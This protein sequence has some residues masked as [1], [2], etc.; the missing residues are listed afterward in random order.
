MLE[1]SARSGFP[2]PGYFSQFSGSVT[3][4]PPLAMEGYRKTM[5]FVSDHLNQMQDGRMMIQN[6]GVIFLS[7]DVDDFFSFCDRCQRLV[8][9]FQRIE[10]LRG[11]VELAEAAVDQDQTGHGLFLFAKTFVSASY[12]FSHAGEIVDACDRLDNEF[13]VVGFLHLAVFPYDH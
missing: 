2:H 11:G 3:D 6:N 7:V 9:D 1:Q 10:R 4:L 8:D 12:D 13:A 5:G